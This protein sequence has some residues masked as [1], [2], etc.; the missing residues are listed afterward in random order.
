L[1]HRGSTQPHSLRGDLSPA[2]RTGE[3]F[4]NVFSCTMAIRAK[5]FDEVVWRISGSGTIASRALTVTACKAVSATTA[6]RK[7]TAW[8]HS[9][10]YGCTTLRRGIVTS[11]EL[12]VERPVLLVSKELGC[13][14]GDER[15]H[16]LLNA[17]PVD[18]VADRADA[19]S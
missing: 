14:P 8:Y 2:F 12:M 10:W 19:S 16:I 15:Q 4:D 17:M 1:W 6:G 5:C 9:H 13:I 3:R 11:D 7:A 18:T